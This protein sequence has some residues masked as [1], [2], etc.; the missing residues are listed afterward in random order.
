MPGRASY[1]RSRERAQDVKDWISDVNPDM[2]WTEYNAKFDALS[3]FWPLIGDF[4]KAYDEIT[5]FER[6]REYHN[7]P[8]DKLKPGAVAGQMPHVGSSMMMLSRNLMKL[9][10]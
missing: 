10:R 6:Y 8:W 1:R 9:Y 7:I 5:E 3:Y 2:D 4:R